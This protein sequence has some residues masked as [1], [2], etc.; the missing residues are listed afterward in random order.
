MVDI[1]LKKSHWGK[2]WQQS[3]PDFGVL[4]SHGTDIWWHIPRLKELLLLKSV[5]FPK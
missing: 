3:R 4:Y 1:I 5:L 2:P